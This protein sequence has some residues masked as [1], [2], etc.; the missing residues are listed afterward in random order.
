MTFSSKGAQARSWRPWGTTSRAGSMKWR[1]SPAGQAFCQAAAAAGFGSLLALP[2]RT[3]QRPAGAVAL[4][5]DAPGV[6][7]GAA[8]DIALLFAAQG[9]TAVRNASLYRACRRMVDDL[10]AALES[11]AVIEQ[12]K[13]HLAGRARYLARRGVPA[14]QPVFAEYQPAR[15]G[16]RLPAGA[17]THHR[18]GVPPARRALGQALTTWL[19]AGALAFLI[20]GGGPC[21]PGGS[22]VLTTAWVKTGCSLSAVPA[23]SAGPH[24]G[25]HDRGGGGRAGQR[26]AGPAGRCRA[27]A[28]RRRRAGGQRLGRAAGRPA[29]PVAGRGRSA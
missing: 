2:L 18:R 9:G 28:H 26:V 12:A 19:N 20:V 7:R 3:D 22:R 1:T 17:R 16:D 11:R 13:G 8:H 4:Y 29:R 27:H 6:L 23:R 25:V 21:D 24:R 15:A 5:G 14:A 10:Q